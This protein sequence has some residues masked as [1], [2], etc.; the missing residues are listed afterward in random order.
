MGV[1]SRFGRGG[2]R[3]ADD[4]LEALMGHV[5]FL[6][7]RQFLVLNVIPKVVLIV[8]TLVKDS[9]KHSTEQLVMNTWK[10]LGNV[11]ESLNFVHG[12]GILEYFDP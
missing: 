4:T 5:L 6:Q 7:L 3:R 11:I 1:D 12:R 10:K 2:N 8:S 9:V